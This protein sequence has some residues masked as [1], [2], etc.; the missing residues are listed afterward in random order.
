MK[1]KYLKRLK[2]LSHHLLT[3]VSGSLPAPQVIIL[4]LEN[5][6][7]EYCYHSWIFKDWG[8]IHE[9][10][11]KNLLDVSRLKSQTDPF[12]ANII[13]VALQFYGINEQEFLDLFGY[14]PDDG[15][16]EI[17]KRIN[18][19]IKSKEREIKEQYYSRLLKFADFL[20]DQQD[21]LEKE[22]AS[23]EF[24]RV[25]SKE[26]VRILWWVFSF[27]PVCFTEGPDD[28]YIDSFS[29]DNE[30]IHGPAEEGG[31]TISCVFIFFGLTNIYQFNALFGV[32]NYLKE[33]SSCKDVAENIVR[34]VRERRA[35][36]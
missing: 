3:E 2:E 4:N 5:G 36:G 13:P 12:L 25:D 34:W 26:P 24:K 30:V 29:K 22:F 20:A 23:I 8:L 10:F 32:N 7:K 16:R 15:R 33:E 1:Q 27:L 17:V 6:D 35:D 18:T 21:P 14:L 31:D 19:L 28:W 9:S 11:P